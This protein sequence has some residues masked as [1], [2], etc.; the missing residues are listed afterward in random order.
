M[1]S[2]KKSLQKELEKYDTTCANDKIVEVVRHHS[3]R[4]KISK[5]KTPKLNVITKMIKYI[6]NFGN[7]HAERREVNVVGEP[8]RGM[9]SFE[10]HFYFEQKAY[11][12]VPLKNKYLWRFEMV[13]ITLLYQSPIFFML[14]FEDELKVYFVKVFKLIISGLLWLYRL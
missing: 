14:Y 3:E 5:R 2:A 4:K 12:G 1:N 9:S 8:P 13:I 11:K 7:I 6:R 10:Y